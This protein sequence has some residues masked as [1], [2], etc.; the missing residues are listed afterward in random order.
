MITEALMPRFYFQLS[1]STIFQL[2]HET[3]TEWSDKVTS[4]DSRVSIPSTTTTSISGSTTG[5]ESS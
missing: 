5:P 2:V 3:L 4:F 1:Q